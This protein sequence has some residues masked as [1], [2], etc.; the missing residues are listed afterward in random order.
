MDTII[1]L[2]DSQSYACMFAI[3]ENKKREDEKYRYS[4]Q[5][6][7]KSVEA[8]S[9]LNLR[10][11]IQTGKTYLD[12]ECISEYCDKKDIPQYDNE[13]DVVQSQFY[14]WIMNSAGRLERGYTVL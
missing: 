3:R 4:R 8:L 13:E 12:D 9:K 10:Y 11:N 1:K 6:I 7:Y 2:K 14:N 5:N